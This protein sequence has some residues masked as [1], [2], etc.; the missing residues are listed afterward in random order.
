MFEELGS[1]LL[2]EMRSLG[3]GLLTGGLVGTADID[4]LKREMEEGIGTSGVAQLVMMFETASKDLVTK[5]KASIDSLYSSNEQRKELV[6]DLAKVKKNIWDIVDLDKK[7]RKKLL[8][9]LKKAGIL[10]NR[11]TAKSWKKAKKLLADPAELMKERIVEVLEKNVNESRKEDVTV[12]FETVL[13]I[14]DLYLTHAIIRLEKREW[15]ELGGT[16]LGAVSALCG[17]FEMALL[18]PL[19]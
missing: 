9:K 7:D 2:E 14:L 12:L 8:K 18:K 3:T 13:A 1:S 17:A 15:N 4:V 16:L 6:K 10:G 5:I 11:P 19:H